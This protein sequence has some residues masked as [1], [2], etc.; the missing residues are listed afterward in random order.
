MEI[1]KN[2]QWKLDGDCE[3]CRR[4]SYCNKECK[5]FKVSMENEM[6]EIFI[7]ALHSAREKVNKNTDTISD[8][9][10]KEN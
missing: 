2:E 7:K 5:A 4:A 10:T 9:I 3:L 1:N 6:H 8:D